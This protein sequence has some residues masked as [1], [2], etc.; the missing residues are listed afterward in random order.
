MSA[1]LRQSRRELHA[2]ATMSR[3]AQAAANDAVAAAQATHQSYLAQLQH[4]QSIHASMEVDAPAAGS[5]DPLGSATAIAAAT[6]AATGPEATATAAPEATVP[7][8]TA[9]A[10]NPNYVVPPSSPEAV[11]TAT[12]VPEAAATEARGI[13]ICFALLTI[14]QLSTLLCVS[15]VA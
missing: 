14:Q 3:L 11:A 10:I 1:E 8:A 13:L 9:T 2:L 15:S 7:E 4:V 5:T 12:A 6:A